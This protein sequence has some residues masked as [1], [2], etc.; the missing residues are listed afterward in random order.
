MIKLMKKKEFVTNAWKNLILPKK[1]SGSNKLIGGSF[2]ISVSHNK[3]LV[4]APNIQELMKTL[5]MRTIIGK[6]ESRRKLNFPNGENINTDASKLC[7]FCCIIRKRTRK[8]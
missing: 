3:L 8:S 6:M 5:L 7:P 1:I 2:K 4:N